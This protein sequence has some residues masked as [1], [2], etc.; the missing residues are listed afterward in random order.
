MVHLGVIY[1]EY[2]YYI[3]FNTLEDKS[4][5]LH[6][7]CLINPLEAVNF[8]DKSQLLFVRDLHSTISNEEI[9][10]QDFLV[11]C[12]KILNKCLWYTPFTVVCSNL[13]PDNSYEVFIEMNQSFTDW[14]RGLDVIWYKVVLN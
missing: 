2:T 9:F 4:F 6:E 13:Q 5:L 10:L 14:W 1:Y 7:T 11:I 3:C 12:K 8:D